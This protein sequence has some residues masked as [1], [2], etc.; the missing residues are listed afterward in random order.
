MRE[1]KNSFVRHVTSHKRLNLYAI[2]RDR[3]RTCDLSI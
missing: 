2:S 1:R 3:I